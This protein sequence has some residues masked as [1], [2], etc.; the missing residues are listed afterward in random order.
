MEGSEQLYVASKLVLDSRAAYALY[1]MASLIGTAL[2]DHDSVRIL[3]TRARALGYTGAVLIH[4]SHVAVAA[5]VFTP[6][7]EE[8]EYCAGLIEAMREAQA[9]GDGAVS[10]RGMMVDYA[11]LPQAEEVVGEARRR[12]AAAP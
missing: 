4:P 9:R 5:A 6:S 7:P 11:M 10:Y 2:D 12:A 1:P 8:V 3:A